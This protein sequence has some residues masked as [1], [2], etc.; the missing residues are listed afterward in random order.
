MEREMMVTCLRCSINT[1]PWM[2]WV[3]IQTIRN[4]GGKGERTRIKKKRIN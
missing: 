2:S 1:V 4:Q 3:A